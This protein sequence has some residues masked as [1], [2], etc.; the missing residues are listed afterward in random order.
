MKH[1]GTLPLIF[2]SALVMA[3]GASRAQSANPAATPAPVLLGAEFHPGENAHYAFSLK[4]NLTSQVDP[5]I[6]SDKVLSFTPR[7]YQVEGEIVATFAPTQPGEPLRGTVQFQGLTV[8]NWVSSANVAD[9]EV[10]PAPA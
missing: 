8:K 3:P 6:P 5:S 1:I 10:Q 2:F 7:Q 4:M 9:L